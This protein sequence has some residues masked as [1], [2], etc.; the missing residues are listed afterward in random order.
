M[1]TQPDF[2]AVLDVFYLDRGTLFG[3]NLEPIVGVWRSPVAHLHG[4]Q[5]VASSNL[6]TP[7]N[8]KNSGPLGPLFFHK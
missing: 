3:Y 4:V 7:T 6:V 5:G 8:Y 1:R 2:K